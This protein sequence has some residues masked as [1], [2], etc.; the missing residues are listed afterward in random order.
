MGDYRELYTLYEERNDLHP[1][2]P[3]TTTAE[4]ELGKALRVLDA[5]LILE[6]DILIG[7]VAR[8]YEM[9]GFLFGLNYGRT[10]G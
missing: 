7:R 6:L 9:Q 3:E 4:S 10:H 5:D 2:T 1:S 8:A